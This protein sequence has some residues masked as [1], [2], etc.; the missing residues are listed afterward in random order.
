M[1]DGIDKLIDTALKLKSIII[2]TDNCSMCATSPT[3]SKVVIINQ[4]FPGDTPDHETIMTFICDTCAKTPCY[5]TIYSNL[6]DSYLTGGA[7]IVL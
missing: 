3:V 2:A 4:V 6:I 7:K 1:Y 5:D